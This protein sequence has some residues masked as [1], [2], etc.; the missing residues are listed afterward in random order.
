MAENKFCSQCGAPLAGDSRF[1]SACG[2]PVDEAER[3]EA[4][5]ASE[6]EKRIS[7]NAEQVK[8]PAPEKK[9]PI[10]A[11]RRK[12]V[13]PENGK[14]SRKEK[15]KA[16]KAAKKGRKG[17]GGKRGKF[18]ADIGDAYGEYPKINPNAHW[19]SNF[20]YCVKNSKQTFIATVILVVLTL[21]L[22]VLDYALPGGKMAVERGYTGSKVEETVVPDEETSDD[23]ENAEDEEA[24]K[25]EEEARRAEEE[26]QKA[27]EEAKKEEEAAQGGEYLCAYSSERA[28]TE[29]D[30][31]E[32]RNSDYGSLPDGRSLEQMMIN[33]I[34]ARHGYKFSNEK[35]LDYFKQKDWYNEIG[36][37]SSSQETVAAGFSSTEKA[38]VEFL[39]A[40]S[41]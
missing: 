13:A 3:A 28:L 29:S 14:P 20:V 1:C 23:G 32:L 27:E 21:L 25:A 7:V 40:H 18:Q 35:I 26:A 8:D 33:E 10:A 38:N 9:K 34:Y 39:K 16:A 30:L 12:P 6:S 31:K 15:A 4:R 24:L 37:Y 17:K 36:S 41:N 11:E 2:A 5:K 22:M 19:V